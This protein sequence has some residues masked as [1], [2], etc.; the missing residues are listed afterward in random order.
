MTQPRRSALRNS[1]GV[2]VFPIPPVVID[3]VGVVLPSPP[4]VSVAAAVHRH[5]SFLCRSH[6]WI[7]RDQVR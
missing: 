2:G 4:D 6:Y 1:S 5:L 7:D 3:G